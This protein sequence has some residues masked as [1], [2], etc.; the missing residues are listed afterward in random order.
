MDEGF[1][2]WVAEAIKGGPGYDSGY[3]SV[4]AVLDDDNAL[5]RY[6]FRYI[7]NELRGG[8]PSKSLTGW[9]VITC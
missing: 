7:I 4:E 2:S 3:R 9:A 6:M 1:I 8:R 5:P